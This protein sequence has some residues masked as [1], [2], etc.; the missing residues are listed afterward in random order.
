MRRAIVFDLDGT[1]VDSAPDIA[2]AANRVLSEMDH[3]PLPVPL[4]T[5]FIGHGI[6]RLVGRVIE[7]LTLDPAQHKA[8]TTRMLAHY[9]E[10]PADL[11]RPY[12]GV[13]AALE[14]LRD[15][16]HVMGVCTNK[17][18][19]LSVQVLDA[20]GLSAFFEV[21][22]GGDCLPQKKPDPA[23]LRAAFAALDATPLL[24][25]G[26]SEVDAETA[27]AIALPFGL[28]TGGYRS[29][30]VEDLPHSFAFDHFSSLSGLVGA[31]PGREHNPLTHR[32]AVPTRPG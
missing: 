32:P 29:T 13:V 15:T 3:A 11:T 4:L 10:R 16:G 25:V 14:A 26:D 27:H 12:P 17:Y 21:V 18:R 22:I 28:H 7:H 1:L 2:A 9:T 8:M 23:P 30:P 20:L 24:Y 31:L 6:P 19:G 5:S